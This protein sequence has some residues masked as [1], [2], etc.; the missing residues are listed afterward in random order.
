MGL[1]RKGERRDGE[2]V[3][4]GKRLVEGEGRKGRGEGWRERGEG[5]REGENGGGGG[6]KGER[7][8]EKE[9]G[10]GR[11]GKGREGEREDSNALYLTIRVSFVIFRISLRTR[12][13]CYQSSL[14][15]TDTKYVGSYIHVHSCRHVN[16]E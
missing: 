15:S 10:G 11:R 2:K 5:A 3:R 9:A 7:G 13:H 6:I 1:R 12:E 4:G 16:S 8:R 14:A